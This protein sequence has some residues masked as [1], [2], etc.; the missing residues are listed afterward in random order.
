MEKEEETLEQSPQVDYEKR[1]SDIESKIGE[2]TNL[3]AEL[4]DM[5]VSNINQQKQSE[6]PKQEIVQEKKEKISNALVNT[7][8]SKASILVN[9]YQNEYNT[10]IDHLKKIYPDT[11]FEFPTVKV[12]DGNRWYITVYKMGSPISYKIIL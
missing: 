11:E 2:L 12:Y 1:I 9:L 5:L 4:F 10:L 8:Q 3:K 6:T 7:N